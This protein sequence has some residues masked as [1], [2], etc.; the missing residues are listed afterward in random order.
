[1]LNLNRLE[2]VKFHGNK[3]TAAC[4][5]CRA[6][7]SDKSGNHLFI[8]S[9]DGSGPY[10]CIKGCCP[11]DIFAAVGILENRELTPEEKNQWVKQKRERELKTSRDRLRVTNQNKLTERIQ[12]ILEKKLAPY[13]S[14]DW[15]A[16]L[17]HDS[18]IRFD[19]PEAAPYD[20]I[21]SLFN[22]DDILW[23]GEDQYAT[24]E[25]KHAANFRT[26]RQWLMLDTLPPRIAAGTFR[27]GCISRSLTNV[28]TS[29]Y[30]IIESD[31]LIGHEPG[32]PDEKQRNKSLSHALNL[33][34]QD[35]LGLILRAV[36]DTGNKSLHSW[37]DRPPDPAM[38]ALQKMA[39]GLRIDKSVLDACQASPLRMPHCIHEKTDTSARLLYLN[40]TTTK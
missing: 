30:I 8:N 18:P 37:Y 38:N 27:Q 23:M 34:A 2:N 40:P 4:V 1:M 25:P 21:L 10:G 35:K 36:I 39:A 22:P 9:L 3:T 12:E 15:Q 6:A 7:G 26:C 24:G 20:F 17:W 33:Y 16:D 29:P 31:E 11:K 14:N 5:L 32:T 19:H 28:L 13:I